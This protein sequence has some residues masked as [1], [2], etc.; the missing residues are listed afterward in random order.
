MD[1]YS[2]VLIY[3]GVNGL[4]PRQWRRIYMYKDLQYRGDG[5]IGSFLRYNMMS[6]AMLLL[7]LLFAFE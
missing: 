1:R 4:R 3:Y 2:F 7:F 5:L 6:D